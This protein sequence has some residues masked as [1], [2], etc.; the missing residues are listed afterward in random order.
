MIFRWKGV[1]F[2]DHVNYQNPDY[3]T[4]FRS[5]DEAI[6]RLLHYHV[7]QDPVNREKED[8]MCKLFSCYWF[9]FNTKSFIYPTSFGISLHIWRTSCFVCFNTTL[10][11]IIFFTKNDIFSDYLLQSWF[12]LQALISNSFYMGF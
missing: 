12:C 10:A 7:S 1:L 8:K 11:Q 9:T 4:P 2:D 6:Q 5:S 3:K